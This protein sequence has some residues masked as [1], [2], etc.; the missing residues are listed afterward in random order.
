MEFDIAK[1]K[2]F[3]KQ[4]SSIECVA[5]IMVEIEDHLTGV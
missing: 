4:I 5:R 1:D 3:S 2:R